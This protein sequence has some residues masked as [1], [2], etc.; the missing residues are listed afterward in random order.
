MI[1]CEEEDVNFALLRTIICFCDVTALAPT[2]EPSALMPFERLFLFLLDEIN[3]KPLFPL[4]LDPPCLKRDGSEV[5][6]AQEHE[7]F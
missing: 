3:T 4:L 2:K 5:L 1:I 7:I 6:V